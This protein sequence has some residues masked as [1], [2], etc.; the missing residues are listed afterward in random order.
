MNFDPTRFDDLTRREL[1]TQIA[2]SVLGVSVLPLLDR[3]VTAADPKPVAKATSAA[4]GKAQKIV[5]L[6]MTG[7][8]SQLDTWDPK[9]KSKYQGETKAIQTKI[10]GVQFGEHFKSLA[11]IADKL[12]VIRS[13][14][15]TTADHQ[16]ARY[17]LET[18]YKMIATTKHP[19][20]GSWV[21]KSLGRIHKQLPPVVH[22]GEGQGPGYLGAAFAPVPIGDPAKGLQN[23]KSPDYLKDEMFDKRMKLSEQFDASFRSKAKNAKVNGYDDLYREA[24]SLLRS[25]DLKAFDISSEK[26]EVKDAYG[27]TRFGTACLLA[28]RLIE[29]DV[30]YVQVTFGS[31]DMHNEIFENMPK[32]GPELDK[33]VSTLITDLQKRGLLDSTMVVLATEFGR[34]PRISST[35]GRDHHPAAF[36]A[37]MCGGGIKGGQ[38][39]G[40]SDDDAFYVEDNGIQPGDFNATIAK[41][42]SIPFDKEIYSPDGR[43]FTLANGGKPVEKL[44]S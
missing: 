35:V 6:M 34:T 23:T 17:L 8:Q 7:A 38:V 5:Y 39:Y 13:L 40:K 27:T 24:I 31:W 15:T 30:R 20:M 37:M 25:Q 18:S 14:N 41:A 12:A 11:G 33:V 29:N 42:L 26:Q 43:P 4:R 32:L 22:V 44:L 10:S 1:M 19:G 9:P 2:R 21:Q 3:A 36:S 28:R 16:Q